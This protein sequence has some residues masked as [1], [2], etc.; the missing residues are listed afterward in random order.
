MVNEDI[1]K[2]V[3][4]LVEDYNGRSLFTFR[5]YKLELD[6]DLNNDFRMDPLDAYE[7]LERYAERFGINPETITFAEYFPEDFNAPHDP[8][9]IR[10]LIESAL[11]GRWLGK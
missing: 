1:E 2:A 3:F 11:A 8:L 10:L 6:T 9:T 7:L 4:A 5:R